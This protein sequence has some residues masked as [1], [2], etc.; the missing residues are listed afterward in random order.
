MALREIGYVLSGSSPRLIYFVLREGAKALLGRYYIIP[1]PIKRGSPVLV[2]VIE[3]APYNPDMAL[4]RLG[5]IAA[6]KSSTFRYGK[7]LEYEVAWA[8]VLGYVD[9]GRWLRLECS[10]ESWSPVLE[11]SL[12]ELKS[13]LRADGEGLSVEVG[14]HRDIDIPVRLDLDAVARGHMLI[15]G[16]TRSGKSSF[17]LNMVLQAMSLEPTP[18]FVILDA[19][20]E[21]RPL[22][23]YGAVIVPHTCFSRSLMTVP[24]SVFP[25]MLGFAKCSSAGKLVEL[26]LRDVQSS[27]SADL[28]RLWMRVQQL[29]STAL[30]RNH[31]QVLERIRKALQAK[32]SAFGASPPSIVGL[33]HRYPVVVVDF[34]LDMNLTGKLLAVKY[35]IEELTRHAISRAEAGDFAAIVVLEEAQRYVPE[36]GLDLKGVASRLRVDKAIIEAVSQTGGYN[37][38]FVVVSQRPAYI[39]KSVIS[40]CNTVVCFRTTCSNDLEAL[41]NHADLEGELRAIL[42]CLNDHEALL[43]GSASPFLFPVVVRTRVLELPQKALTPA[44]E[45]WARMEHA[46][47]NGSGGIRTH[48]RPGPSRAS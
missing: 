23:K 47:R 39:S 37:L 16:M 4:G 48:D 13:L 31:Q 8:Q 29:A 12:E 1:H 2:R 34:S 36:R 35:L 27:G 22:A 26:A 9:Q 46:P 6:K 19:R 45:A 7:R 28:Q 25:N 5:P 44:K 24:P 33:L 20:S 21:Y 32:T 3:S 30:E 41:S 40:Q 15:S 38:G 10:P 43:W 17:V 42:P 14:I 18:R 11:P